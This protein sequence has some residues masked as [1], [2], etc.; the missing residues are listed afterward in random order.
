MNIENLRSEVISYIDTNF[1][2]CPIKYEN[3]KFSVPNNSAWV[4]TYL[5]RGGL[6]QS[7]FA[8]SDY[9]VFGVLIFQVFTPANSGSVA[10]N[11]ILDELSSLFADKIVGNV[12]FGMP[13]ISDVGGTGSWYQVNLSIPFSRK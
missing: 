13:S 3:L 11:N 4:A 12:W 2:T 5:K 8:N 10:S 6:N 1:S 7:E 9:E